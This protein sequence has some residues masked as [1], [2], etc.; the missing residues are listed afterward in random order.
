MSS[1]NPGK[2]LPD[3][4][5][6]TCFSWPFPP[7]QLFSLGKAENGPEIRQPLQIFL[8]IA[9]RAP[10]FSDERLIETIAPLNSPRHNPLAFRQVSGE[11]SRDKFKRFKRAAGADTWPSRTLTTAL[12]L[13]VLLF[14]LL[15]QALFASENCH[16]AANIFSL[17]SLIGYLR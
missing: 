14:R 3:A 2:G 16:I 5:L 6:M 10:A 7:L 13:L 8:H 17:C 11:T 12:G 1:S 15:C 9:S 4:R